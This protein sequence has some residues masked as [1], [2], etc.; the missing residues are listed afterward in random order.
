MTN[1]LQCLKIL[2]HPNL[3]NQTPSTSGNCKENSSTFFSKPGLNTT[4]GGS[5][6]D[7]YNNSYEFDETEFIKRKAKFSP[8]PGTENL[9]KT[10]S[11]KKGKRRKNAKADM[12]Q[13]N[14]LFES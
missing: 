6:S 8:S 1:Q 4:D 10:V 3:D 7:E 2:Y 11:N 14:F 9:Y 12:S 5:S 13:E